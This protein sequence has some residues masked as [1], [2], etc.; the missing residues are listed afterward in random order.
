M[1]VSVYECEP[2]SAADLLLQLPV[3]LQVFAST[4]VVVPAVLSRSVAVAQS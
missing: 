4:V 3:L 2:T 1:S